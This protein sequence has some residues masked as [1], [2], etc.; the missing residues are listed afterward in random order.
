MV[1]KKYSKE[2]LIIDRSGLFGKNKNNSDCH[3]NCTAGRDMVVVTT[4]DNV[5]SCIFLA[6][7]G[8]EI[9]KLDDGKILLNEYIE[10]DGNLC[11]AQELCNNNK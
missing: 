2:Q 9:G 6:K 5:Y 8:L 11:L 10:N 4:D 1:R 3:F 7:Q